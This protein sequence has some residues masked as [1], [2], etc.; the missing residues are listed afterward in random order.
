[1]P[2][3]H[4]FDSAVGYLDGGLVINRV[5]PMSDPGC[6][7]FR[8]GQGIFRQVRV[9]EVR[10]DFKIDQ[11]QHAVAICGRLPAIKVLPDEPVRSGRN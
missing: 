6:P 4:D 2:L 3:G 8:V 11:P 5:R 7:P 10:K 9:I 1:M